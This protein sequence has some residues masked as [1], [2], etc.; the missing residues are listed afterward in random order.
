MRGQPLKGRRRVP[1]CNHDAIG[2]E[3]AAARGD[4]NALRAGFDPHH[5]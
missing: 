2:L 3:P 5:G 4:A 1:G